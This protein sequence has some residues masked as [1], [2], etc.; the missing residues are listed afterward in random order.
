MNMKSIKYYNIHAQEFY[1]RTIHADM[2]TVYDKFLAYLRPH[3]KILDAGCGVGRDAKFF[4]TKGHKVEA[5]DGSE[6]MVRL[7]TNGLNQKVLHMTFQDI[8]F[9]EEFDAVGHP[10][11]FYMSLM[12]SLI[13]L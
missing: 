3:S 10:H 4:I 5:F 13:T 1:E 2:S 7:A 6:E 11:P 12:K 8:I 9:E